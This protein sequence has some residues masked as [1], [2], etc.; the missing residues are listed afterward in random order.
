MAILTDRVPPSVTTSRYKYSL[1]ARYGWEHNNNDTKEF[2]RRAG[3]R[4]PEDYAAC[5]SSGKG[6][7]EPFS[8]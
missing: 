4:S 6:I 1:C 2:Y 5:V 7:N 3:L 8:V